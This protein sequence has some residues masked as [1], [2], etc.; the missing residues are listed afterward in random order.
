MNIQR[1]LPEVNPARRLTQAT[2]YRDY[3]DSCFVTYVA[4]GSA[5]HNLFFII[6]ARGIPYFS[7]IEAAS[8]WI[9]CRTSAVVNPLDSADTV[10]FQSH[11][12][13]N[14]RGMALSIFVVIIFHPHR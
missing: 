6:D 11:T 7:Q 14:A 4:P 2:A 10:A 12:S 13:R 3:F 1:A 8:R 9:A 5:A